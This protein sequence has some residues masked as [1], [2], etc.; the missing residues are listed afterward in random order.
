MSIH[1]QLRN[2]GWTALHALAHNAHALCTS[3]PGA[4]CS[5][6]QGSADFSSQY[7]GTY[8]KTYTGRRLSAFTQLSLHVLHFS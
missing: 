8:P 3:W 2:I 7:S 1:D 4:I 5:I 6:C